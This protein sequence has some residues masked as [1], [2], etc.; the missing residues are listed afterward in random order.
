MT[1]RLHE[2]VCA[3]V[4]SKD[5][6]ILACIGNTVASRTRAEIASLCWALVMLYWSPVSNSAHC[7]E[8]LE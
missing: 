5:K 7:S 4:D 8:V 1:A 2:L 3:Q 6:G